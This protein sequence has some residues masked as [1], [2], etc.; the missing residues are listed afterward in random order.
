MKKRLPIAEQSSSILNHYDGPIN[1][2]ALVSSHS[3]PDL[4]KKTDIFLDCI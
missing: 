1:S 4:V 3:P 2:Y